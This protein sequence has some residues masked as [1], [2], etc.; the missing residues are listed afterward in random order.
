MTTNKRLEIADERFAECRNILESKGKSYAGN[1]DALYNF[2]QVAE[3]TGL[4][5]FQV[6]SIYFL[7]HVFSL[8]NAIKENPNKPKDKS[9]GNEGRVTD[10]INYTILF[11][12]LDRELSQ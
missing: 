11:E 5:P 10:V 3:M 8:T 7:K 6:W 2:K 12:C 1:E 4:T 9:E